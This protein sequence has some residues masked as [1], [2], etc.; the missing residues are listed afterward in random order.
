MIRNWR[1]E[2]GQIADEH[3]S[4]RQNVI[5][6][7]NHGITRPDLCFMWVEKSA[8]TG[9]IAFSADNRDSVNILDFSLSPGSHIGAELIRQS[10]SLQRV[11][12]HLYNDSERYGEYKQCF[13]N[14]GFIAAQEKL[15][16]RFTKKSIADTPDGVVFRTYADAG[17]QVFIEAVAAV[18]RQTLDRA[19]AD[20]VAVYGEYK[21]AEILV[22]DLKEL[23]F[24]PDIWTLAYDNNRFIGLVIPSNFGDSYGGINY[25]GVAPEERGRGYVNALLVKG[26]QLLL[27]QGVTAIIADIDVL[28]YPMKSALENNGYVFECEETVLEKRPSGG[29]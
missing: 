3:K 10:N 22:N 7:T 13:I 21:A 23:D 18:T 28:N 11:C 29:I 24:Q 20:S 6:W 4:F 17:E 1:R 2:D 16:Y 8:V 15:S 14:A 27:A 5:K 9:C 25:I 19:D 12:Y 26:T